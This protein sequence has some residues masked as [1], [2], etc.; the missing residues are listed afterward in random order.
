MIQP[1]CWNIR[2]FGSI[3]PPRP[4]SVL[5]HQ[6]K[7]NCFLINIAKDL[8]LRTPC[9]QT[10]GLR[11]QTRRQQCRPGGWACRNS[12]RR[13]SSAAALA[14]LT[15][16]TSLTQAARLASQLCR[17]FH[18]H[19][20]RYSRRETG[21]PSLLCRCRRPMIASCHQEGHS[22]PW[23]VMHNSRALSALLCG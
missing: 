1:R 11:R 5:A 8:R 19:G 13:D 4:S 14:C 10:C 22:W 9:R 17:C 15:A 2:S 20:R 6:R 21:S 18:R 23:S 16:R 7:Y 3:C 12:G